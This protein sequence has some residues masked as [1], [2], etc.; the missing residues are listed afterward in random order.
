MH[1]QQRLAQEL[2]RQNRGKKQRKK[3][4]QRSAENSGKCEREWRLV[5][6]YLSVQECLQE[7]LLDSAAEGLIR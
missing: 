5:L 1:R 3:A 4:V 7:E 2:W 6:T